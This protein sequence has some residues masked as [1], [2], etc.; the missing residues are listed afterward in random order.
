MFNVGA[1][2]ASYVMFNI[3]ARTASY[4]MFNVGARTASYVM[5]NV[6]A[7]T[8]SYG[9]ERQLLRFVRCVRMTSHANPR[10]KTLVLAS[11]DQNAGQN[12]NSVLLTKYHSGDLSQEY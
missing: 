10:K 9:S 2:T 8:A 11:R 7:R 1:R 6:G 3:G 12:G 4:V 5:L